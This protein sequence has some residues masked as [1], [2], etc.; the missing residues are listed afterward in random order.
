MPHPEPTPTPGGDAV[1]FGPFEAN[2]RT[3]ELFRDGAPV[4]LQPQPFRVLAALVRRRGELVTREELRREVWGEH[5]AVDFEHGLNFCVKQVRLA[6]GDNAEKPAYVET[7]PK[8]GYRFIG[9]LEDARAAPAEPGGP[10]AGVTREPA[11]QSTATAAPPVPLVRKR[12]AGAL[13]VVASIA[14]VVA[15]AALAHRARGGFANATAQGPAVLLV[16][17]F[18]NLTGDASEDGLADAIAADT[19]DALDGLDPARVAVLARGTSL[20]VRGRDVAEAMTELRADYAVNGA[21]RAV[22]A[23]EV[24]VTA[25]L[26]RAR[27][28]RVVWSE[29]Y[30]VHEGDL[31]AA[32]RDL[33]R[34]I[35]AALSV[36]L[37]PTGARPSPPRAAQ[38]AL[39]KGRY[40]A[41]NGGADAPP[42]A[43]E[44][45]ENAL[46]L[47]PANADALAELAMLFEDEAG[48]IPA[49]E[50]MAKA[51]DAADRALAAS[52]NC[53]LAHVAKAM[54]AIQ[55]DWDWSA[56]DASF[57][58]AIALRPG[59]AETH[60]LYAAF[61]SGAGRHAEALAAIRR[62]EELDPL[63]SPVVADAGWHAYLARDYA[64]AV[65][66]FSRTLELEPGDRWTLEHRM[67]ARA[68]AGDVA[69]AQFDAFEWASDSAL[70]PEVLAHLREVP[71]LDAVRDASRAIALL[72]LERER[73]RANSAGPFLAA[74]LAAGGE[75]EESLAWL[76]RATDAHASWLVMALR[77][78]RFDH[79]RD[80]PR[81]RAI[82]ERVHLPPAVPLTASRR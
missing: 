75:D 74:T 19:I 70:S 33:S 6:L 18:A 11:P 29:G 3:L 7:L 80:T 9:A 25:E 54:V 79:L 35:A 53:A 71:P 38:E 76:E 2:L 34:A 13:A 51:R 61:L 4:K 57:Q 17:P 43:I 68:L 78:P 60:H 22:E 66:E 69:G 72:R 20:A 1:R 59:A 63:S 31:V 42:R 26:V 10:E 82:T 55:D 27:D 65:A 14:L 81:F 45:Y 67:N 49:R 47:D 77:D 44:A 24:R 40:L 23:G 48:T 52:P 64:A 39:R 41:R 8:R 21:V 46:K 16:L 30:D 37:D 62:A 58:R 15:V 73:A 5:T 50:A 32:E 36:H 12:Y 28:A 56:S